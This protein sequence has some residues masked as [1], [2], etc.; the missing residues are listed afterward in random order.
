MEEGESVTPVYQPFEKYSY[1]AHHNYHLGLTKVFTIY[2]LFYRIAF[3]KGV[4]LHILSTDARIM[5]GIPELRSD[6][7]TIIGGL[8]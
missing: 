5:F 4:A 3:S 1:K 2:K 8:R 6:K 7:L